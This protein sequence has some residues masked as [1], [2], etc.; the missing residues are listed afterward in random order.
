MLKRARMLIVLRKC[1]DRGYRVVGHA[2]VLNVFGSK[3]TGDEEELRE[4]SLI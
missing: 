4:I 3:I 2:F 1:E